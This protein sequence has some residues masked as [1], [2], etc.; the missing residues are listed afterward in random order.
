M[1]PHTITIMAGT[2]KG[3]HPIEW[4]SMSCDGKD[5][6]ESMRPE[7]SWT[8]LRMG[9]SCCAPNSCDDR[10]RSSPSD[11]LLAFRQSIPESCGSYLKIYSSGDSMVRESTW[12]LILCLFS[13]GDFQYV[14]EFVFV[15]SRVRHK[16]TAITLRIYHVLIF[17]DYPL[18]L[19][20]L[21]KVRPQPLPNYWLKFLSVNP[22]RQ[23]Q[24]LNDAQHPGYGTTSED[25]G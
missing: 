10:Q 22:Y 5:D 15:S 1:Y 23:N 6:H 11:S 20:I 16:L 3:S 9:L 2:S 21:L 19:Q 18:L 12:T 7:K 24:R 25:F 14:D 8:V 4:K 17:I 13:R